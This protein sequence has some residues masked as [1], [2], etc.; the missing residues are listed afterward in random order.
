LQTLPAVWTFV[1]ASGLPLCRPTTG[2][3]RA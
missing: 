2:P 1:A 3:R